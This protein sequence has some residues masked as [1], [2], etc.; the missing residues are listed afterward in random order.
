ME[1]EPNMTMRQKQAVNT[2][3]KL[4][5]AAVKLFLEKGFDMV[6]IDDITSE[7]G[8]AKG[9]F[10]LYFN[11]K[12]HIIMEE[13]SKIDSNAYPEI[14]KR[15]DKSKS[16]S[17]TLLLFVKEQHAY[18]LEHVGLDMLK[19]VYYC[20]LTTPNNDRIAL[21]NENRSLYKILETIVLRG[22]ESGEF[23]TD[24]ST[25]YLVQ[26]ITFMMRSVI[27]EWCIHNGSFDLSAEGQR[28]FKLFINGM[29]K[30]R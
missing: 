26:L 5:K 15:I 9:T 10:Y 30:A 7:A 17:E 19:V 21:A 4:H 8:T 3:Q 20:Q 2:K 29:V 1:N 28:F 11:N 14:F 16:A 22:Q 27:Y 13:F 12:E 18:A 25:K 24:I 23:R 6:S